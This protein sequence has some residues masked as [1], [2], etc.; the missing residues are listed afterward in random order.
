M[1]SLDCRLQNQPRSQHLH[2]GQSAVAVHGT[3]RRR[4][5]WPVVAAPGE[6][7]EALLLVHSKARTL[8]RQWFIG[9]EE[10]ETLTVQWSI[11][12]SQG[13]VA[14]PRTEKDIAVVAGDQNRPVGRHSLNRALPGYFESVP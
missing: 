11:N 2:Q 4:R 1:C 3:G 8:H 6:H 12:A 14:Q 7:Y 5:L 13:R 9:A 10:L